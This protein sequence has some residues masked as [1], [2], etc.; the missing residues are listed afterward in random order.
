M[1]R[2]VSLLLPALLLLAAPVMAQDRL[3]RDFRIVRA[4]ADDV[5]TLRGLA[6]PEHA[7]RDRGGLLQHQRPQQR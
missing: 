7:G 2:N 4:C 6:V 1:R 3:V 5:V